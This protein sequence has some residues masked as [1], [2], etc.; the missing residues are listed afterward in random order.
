MQMPLM[1]NAE[2]I[3]FVVLFLRG[4]P[5]AEMWKVS[6]QLVVERGTSE[7]RKEY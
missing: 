3:A 2:Y 1:Q 5:I 7:A 6:W 4:V